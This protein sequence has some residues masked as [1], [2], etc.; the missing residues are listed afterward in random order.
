MLITYL[1]YS[2][3][4]T[5]TTTTSHE[6]TTTKDSEEITTKRHHHRKSKKKKSHEIS[7][8]KSKKRSTEKALRILSTNSDIDIFK[9]YT[10]GYQETDKEK[11][12]E[13]TQ[14]EIDF[15]NS[16]AKFNKQLLE[17][18]E[19]LKNKT[20]L[21]SEKVQTSTGKSK[22]KFEYTS[23]KSDNKLHNKHKKHKKHE[24]SEKKIRDQTNDKHKKKH[25]KPEFELPKK[26]GNVAIEV[27]SKHQQ[28]N[29]AF[30]IDS[31][32]DEIGERQKKHKSVLFG[33]N[34]EKEKNSGYKQKIE[35]VK[36]YADNID[37]NEAGDEKKVNVDDDDLENR[38]QHKQENITSEP[39]N[40]PKPIGRH[41][42]KENKTVDTHSR[43]KHKN[44]KNH[45]NS[46]NKDENPNSSHKKKK[47]V[48][49]EE[50]AAQINELV[51]DGPNRQ[52][53]ENVTH[54]QGHKKNV[55]KYYD[56]PFAP[57]KIKDDESIN[58]FTKQILLR[59]LRIFDNVRKNSSEYQWKKQ[60]KHLAE[61]YEEKFKEFLRSSAQQN[62]KTK[63]GTQKVVLNAI[64]MSK[65]IANRLLNIMVHEID[66][67]GMLRTSRT[68]DVFY[69]EL[70]KEVD[71]E[72]KHA[73]SKLGICSSHNGFVQIII[74][75]IGTMLSLDDIRF[76][77]ALDS[78][79]DI[80]QFTDFS[81]TLSKAN[82]ALL[83]RRM[84]SFEKED[85]A[86][87]RAMFAIIKNIL[88]KRNKPL[89][90]YADSDPKRSN[91]NGTLAFLEVI[92][93]LDKKVPINEANINEWTEIRERMLK[94]PS[95]DSIQPTITQFILYI[96]KTID[97]LDSKNNKALLKN[98]GKMF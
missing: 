80:I 19:Q 57:H 1:V 91:I 67:K 47:T 5:P 97:G 39:T 81:H 68:H 17:W 50:I 31:D 16:F 86:T 82:D 98:F 66:K 45:D 76:K 24:L 71:S 42:Q 89:V 75:V 26:L 95:G 93:I 32:N 4:T 7:T 9:N 38:N 8:V 44:H 73:C 92:D 96:G 56:K 3:S 25:S 62:I 15:K 12:Q 54:P 14:A 27:R 41:R 29:T 43:H 69:T 35:T 59:T 74:D 46:E 84:I 79:T 22:P 58:S 87:Q 72:L 53:H 30:N 36:E 94:W 78:L 28:E 65:Q 70:K 23:E 55:T 61:N 13:L 34:T 2:S 51:Y 33:L 85:M 52:K 63:L 20:R 37:K 49:V 77:E 83:K 60:V 88:L 64:D 90:M 40:Q 48:T 10:F 21:D 6:T 11:K 18:H